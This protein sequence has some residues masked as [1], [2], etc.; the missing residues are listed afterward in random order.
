MNLL[1]YST[2][3]NIFDGKNTNL[4]TRPLLSLQWETLAQKNPEH[5]F[6]IA[7]QLPGMFLLDVKENQIAQ[8]AQNVEYFLI[9]DDDET[10]IAEFLASLNPDIAFA[11][12]FYAPPFD[13]L[14]VKDSL[15]AQKLQ[16]KGIKTICH[17][18]HSVLTCFDKWQTHE[19]FEKEKIRCAKAIFF[20]HELFINGAN[21]REIKSNV[22]KTAFFEEIKSL[23]FPLI[24]KDTTGLSSYGMDVVQN[25]QEAKAVI[26]SKK[27]SSNRILEEMILGEQFGLE[28]I[29]I[30]KN[31]KTKIKILPPFK[32]SVNK[33]GITS[34]KQSVKVGPI[35]DEK[36]YNLPSLCKMIFKICESL[37]FCGT[38][39]FDLVFEPQEK[40]WFVLEINPRLSG[41]TTSYAASLEKS[42]P[43][44]LFKII[45]GDFDSDDFYSGDFDSGDLKTQGS[46]ENKSSL[47][48]QS[49]QEKQIFYP[50]MNIKFPILNTEKI[51]KAA[52][53]P[54]VKFVNQQENLGARQLR[55]KGYSEIIFNAKTFEELKENLNTLKKEFQAEME[56]IFFENALKLLDSI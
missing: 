16:T 23:K 35:L 33:Y 2:S 51:E 26:L 19:F 5:K 37:D 52:A 8:K 24:I 55:E 22:Y 54:F 6:I 10:K 12:S 32:F 34:P 3:S 41:M 18:L 29:R 30:L 20:N 14:S 31:G 28:A 47:K 15:V 9:Q 39:N 25:F 13:W 17:P 53:L 49:P 46:L 21:R 50:T 11:A 7:T 36:K 43:E 42:I 4:E 38:A 1:F 56:N 44:L 48:T 40:K 27:S 45:C